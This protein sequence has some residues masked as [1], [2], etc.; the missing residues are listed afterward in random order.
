MLLPQSF[1][2]SVARTPDR[3]AV[4]YPN[5]GTEYT[6]AELWDEAYAV[7]TALRERGIVVAF[8][9]ADGDVTDE[10]LDQWREGSNDLANY[11]R[12][13]E[14][15]FLGHLPGERS[16]GPNSTTT[17]CSRRPRH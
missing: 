4:A 6:S 11:K 8:V 1:E 7:G 14:H 5:H 13:A 15:R 9:A 16:S 10:E 2:H 3:T 12:P 17:P